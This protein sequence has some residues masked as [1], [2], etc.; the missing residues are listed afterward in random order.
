M[1][2]RN[3]CRSGDACKNNVCL[4]IHPREQCEE[5]EHSIKRLKK[6]NEV[7]LNHVEEDKYTEDDIRKY[8]E[9]FGGVKVINQLSHDKYT[10]EFDDV[11]SA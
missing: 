8:A 6:N 4:F 2:D 3:P 10:I 11:E 5:D 7:V 9:K 1:C